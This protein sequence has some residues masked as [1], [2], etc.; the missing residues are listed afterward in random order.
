MDLENLKQVWNEEKIE[1]IPEIS[2][3]KQKEIHTPL[4]MIRKNM[5]TEFWT[6]IVFFLLWA[7]SS[8]FSGMDTKHTYLLVILI[9][10]AFVIIGYYY[11]KFYTFYKKLNTQNLN[12]YHNIL[13]L[14]YELVLNS[15][16][17]KSF[18]IASIPFI[19][20]FYYASY[21]DNKDFNLSFFSIISLSF[22]VLIYFIGKYWLYENYGKYIQQ[23]S[24]IVAE[25]TGEEDGFE[26]DRSFLKIQKEFVFLQKT[27][28]FCNEKFGKYGQIVYIKFLLILVLL[29]SFLVG[30]CVAI[31]HII[32][33]NYLH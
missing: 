19:L 17:Y 20:G 29:I 10:T 4:E 12:T 14:R 21:V 28:N 31:L 32:L 6:S 33:T 18:Y 27:R 26:Y 22:C 23:I 2:L 3:E 24:K 25:I 9:L 16:L 8:P 30:I 7:V 1:S 13:D 5:R 15:E 11:L